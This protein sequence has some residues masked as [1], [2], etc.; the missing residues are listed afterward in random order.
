M[1]MKTKIKGIHLGKSY[2]IVIHLITNVFVMHT[3]LQNNSQL[4]KKLVKIH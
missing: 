4:Y 3:T 1:I 2:I